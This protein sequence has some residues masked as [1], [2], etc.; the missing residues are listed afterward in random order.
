[1]A[2]ILI[3][4]SAPAS[5]ELECSCKQRLNADQGDLQGHGYWGRALLRRDRTAWRQLDALFIALTA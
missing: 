4:S 5:L 3:A 2:A 1:M